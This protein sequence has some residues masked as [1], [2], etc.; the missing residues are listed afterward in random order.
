MA[1]SL[2]LSLCLSE[3]KRKE[4]FQNEILNGLLSPTINKI[5]IEWKNVHYSAL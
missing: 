3:L 4:E 5:I 1:G 2:S